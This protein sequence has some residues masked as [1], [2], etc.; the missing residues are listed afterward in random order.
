MFWQKT[1]HQILDIKKLKEK[2]KKNTDP[3]FWL[4]SKIPRKV[5]RPSPY[6]SYHSVSF[7]GEFFLKSLPEKYDF[8]LKEGFSMK[9]MA[10]TRQVSKKNF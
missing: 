3:H 8:N 2:E 9:K 5:L 10:E 7:T 1:N 4:H 6:H